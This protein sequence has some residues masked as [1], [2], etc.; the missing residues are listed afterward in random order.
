MN[1]PSRKQK[2]AVKSDTSCKH[3]RRSENDT[4]EQIEAAWKKLHEAG[5]ID[6]PFDRDKFDFLAKL[7]AGRK[8]PQKKD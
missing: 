6:S 1:W 4:H 8:G 2:Q 3:D 5:D 7:F